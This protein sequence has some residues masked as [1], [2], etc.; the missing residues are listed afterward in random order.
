MNREANRQQEK[1]RKKKN[2]RATADS[3]P[4]PDTNIVCSRYRELAA[5]HTQATGTGSRRA[6]RATHQITGAAD[7]T[8]LTVKDF[9]RAERAGTDVTG[10]S[11]T[12]TGRMISEPLQRD[13]LTIEQ[14]YRRNTE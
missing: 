11:R 2:Q 8:Y 4:E 1:Q 14:H 5:D 7:P 13:I 3:R 6:T 12:S 9:M 10:C